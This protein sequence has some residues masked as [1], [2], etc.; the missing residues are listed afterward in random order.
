MDK[1]KKNL[2][3]SNK[4]II[5]QLTGFFNNLSNCLDQSYFT[6]QKSAYEEMLIW[7][8]NCQNKSMKFIPP[9]N[10]KNYLQEKGTKSKRKLND[11]RNL[12]EKE[13]NYKKANKTNFNYLFYNQTFNN[14]NNND[15]KKFHEFNVYPTNVEKAIYNNSSKTNSFNFLFNNNN[16]KNSQENFHLSLLEFSSK[17]RN[18]N[19]INKPLVGPINNDINDSFDEPMDSQNSIKYTHFNYIDSNLKRK[20]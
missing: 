1:I 14:N 15:E 18:E 4:E 19:N 9:K 16:I 7:F 20:K 12:I 6:G 10:V 3:N 17:N 8:K 5:E 13:D 11:K 2:N